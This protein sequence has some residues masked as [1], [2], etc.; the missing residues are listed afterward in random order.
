MCS[1]DLASGH[2]R[3]GETTT[4]GAGDTAYVSETGHTSHNTPNEDKTPPFF[5]WYGQEELRHAIELSTLLMR[6]Q[7][8]TVSVHLRPP[9][10]AGN[11]D[12]R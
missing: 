3:G 7:L 4:S 11:K 12:R 10:K 6:N 8:L 1:T 2:N 9:R 5:F